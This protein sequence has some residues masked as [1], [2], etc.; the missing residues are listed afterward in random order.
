VILADTS[1]WIDHFRK[2][3]V[4]LERRLQTGAIALHPYVIGE[5]ALGPLPARKQTLVLLDL[6]PQLPVAQQNEVR[7]LI[8]V[9]SLYHQGL[10]LSDAHL[11]ASTLIQPG[12]EL[13]T[14]DR[15]LRRVARKLGVAS[16]LP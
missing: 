5:L 11:L 6:M 9:H 2:P 13:W 3:E 10:G 16:S 15:N 8:E 4:E 12:A 1:V 14:R 7:Q